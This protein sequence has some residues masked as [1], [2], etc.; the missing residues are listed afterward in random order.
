MVTIR[1]N[2]L[3]QPVDGARMTPAERWRLRRDRRGRDR[4]LRL[5]LERGVPEWQLAE[6]V[7]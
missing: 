4:L 7:R 6:V 2:D 3:P 5:L 1:R